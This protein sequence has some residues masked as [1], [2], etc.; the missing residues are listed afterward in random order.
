MKTRFFLVVLCVSSLLSAAHAQEVSDNSPTE[1]CTLTGLDLLTAL[2]GTWTL[3]QGAGMA[4]GGPF[5]IPL[6]P[7]RPVSVSLEYDPTQGVIDLIGTDSPGRMIMLPV[8]SGGAN[9]LVGEQPAGNAAASESGCNWNALP[10]LVA[11]NSYTEV[12]EVIVVDFEGAA[13]C[14]NNMTEIKSSYTSWG[15]EVEYDVMAGAAIFYCPADLLPPPVVDDTGEFRMNM[16]LT[17]RFSDDRSGSGTVQFSGTQENPRGGKI[18][19]AAE[20]PV[21]LTR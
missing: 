3:H 15:D 6:P 7:P 8:A 21:E 18:P 4:M 20:A 14:F 10:I 11:T 19:F 2:D 5:P 17:L 1:F 13:I 16:T 12:D 9:Q